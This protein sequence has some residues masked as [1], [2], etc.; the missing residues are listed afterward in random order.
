[1]E[2]KKSTIVEELV[3]IFSDHDQN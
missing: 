3:K 2:N 1:M